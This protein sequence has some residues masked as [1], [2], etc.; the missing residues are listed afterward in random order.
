MQAKANAT[1]DYAA[2]EEQL[3]WQVYEL[4]APGALTEVEAWRRVR[5]R[6]AA[7]E[8]L[9]V[10]IAE[11]REWAEGLRE[12]LAQES[13]RLE[14]ARVQHEAT[15]KQARHMQT[16]N[17]RPTVLPTPVATHRATHPRSHSICYPPCY[18]PPYPLRVTH[19]HVTQAWRE[20][21]AT[22]AGLKRQQAASRKELTRL[23][24]AAERTGSAPAAA[25]EEG[26]AASAAAAA[27]VPSGGA[28]DDAA[29][30]FG[31]AFLQKSHAAA[32]QPVAAAAAAAA[33]AAGGDEEAEIAELEER[34]EGYQ[35][36]VERAWAEVQRMEDSRY[37]PLRSLAPPCIPLHS[38]TPPCTPLHPL[39]PPYTP[40]PGAAYGG[41][42]AADGRAL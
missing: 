24:A 25:E 38:R 16:F 39:T 21:E 36:A 42:A 19:P 2:L 27:G 15:L 18:P 6:Y 26:G 5:P 40:L 33:A 10:A 31:A 37:A 32:A 35:N 4:R 28:A 12:E 29:A 34:A 11:E 3:F 7:Q 22:M 13:E 17:A 41:R 14:A 20:H 1:V 8:H 9:H 30:A 23:R